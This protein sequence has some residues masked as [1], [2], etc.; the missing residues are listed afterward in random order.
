LKGNRGNFKGSR[1][2]FEGSRGNLKGY[3][4]NFKGSRKQR[5]EWSDCIPEGWAGCRPI[6]RCWLFPTGRA[7]DGTS[8]RHPR[9]NRKPTSYR[10]RRNNGAPANPKEIC[11]MGFHRRLPSQTMP[12]RIGRNRS[13]ILQSLDLRPYRLIFENENA[14]GGSLE[15]DPPRGSLPRKRPP[16]SRP[17]LKKRSP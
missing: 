10:A 1:G 15:E 14:L 12:R 8:T 11:T 7:R 4:G 6:P 13:Q 17:P 5:R 2:N 9:G 3:R 16:R